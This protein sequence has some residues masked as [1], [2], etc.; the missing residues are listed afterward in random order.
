MERRL[1]EQLLK[2][3]RR[4]LNT[5]KMFWQNSD[6]YSD[7]IAIALIQILRLISILT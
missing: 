7:K 5:I 4:C 6:R 2:L 3:S 1:W